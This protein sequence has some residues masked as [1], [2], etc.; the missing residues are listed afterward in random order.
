L[1]ATHPWVDSADIGVFLIG[2]DAGEKFGI[3]PGAFRNP[4]SRCN[5]IS[6]LESSLVSPTD[7]VTLQLSTDDPQSPLPLR[8]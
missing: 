2:F 8:E 3:S 7:R 6:E 5:P 4:E 1:L